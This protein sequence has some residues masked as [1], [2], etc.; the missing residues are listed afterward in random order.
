MR[1]R[2]FD[3]AFIAVILCVLFSNPLTLAVALYYG[4]IFLA[5]IGAYLCGAVAASAAVASDD[6]WWR[7]AAF[8]LPAAAGVWWLAAWDPLTL[9]G[10]AFGAAAGVWGYFKESPAGE[11]PSP[12]S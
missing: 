7:R 10:S 1:Q 6:L 2:L 5:C 4:P 11:R 3:L 12:A 8:G 9:I